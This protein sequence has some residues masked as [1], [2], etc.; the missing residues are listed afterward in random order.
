MRLTTTALTTLC[1]ALLS[2]S[3]A[4]AG[5]VIKPAEMSRDDLAGKLFDSPDTKK[6]ERDSGTVLDVTSLLSS[7]KKFA[8]GMYKAPASRWEINEPYGVDE[9][10]YFL[11]GGVT[12]TSSDG[13]VQTIEA[14]EAVTIPKEWTGVWE[15]EG[16][17]KI[18]V[19]YSE[20]G[21][22]LE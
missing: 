14:G 5:E 2:S 13:S 22:G 10:M 20:D 11:E 18:W 4:V 6:T 21:S 7:D 1:A 17:T 15:T 3:L 8:S 12:L 9:F 19:I 16:Y